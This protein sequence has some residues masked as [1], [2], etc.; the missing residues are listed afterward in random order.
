MVLRHHNEAESLNAVQ[1]MDWE[2]KVNELQAK[3]ASGSQKTSNHAYISLHFQVRSRNCLSLNTHREY[4]PYSSNRGHSF[5][6][7]GSL[8]IFSKDSQLHQ[9]SQ[10]LIS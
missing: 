8:K 6:E 1:K 10:S 9:T 7:P 2:W 5:I 4:N 3:T